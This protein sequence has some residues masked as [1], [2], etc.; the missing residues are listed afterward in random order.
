[1]GLIPGRRAFYAVFLTLAIA[2]LPSGAAAREGGQRPA[3]EA[4]PITEIEVNV[5]YYCELEFSLPSSNGYRITVAG[6]PGRSGV[7]IK[8]VG[9]AGDVDYSTQKGKVTANSIDASFGKLGK[10]SM[11]FRPSDGTRQKLFSKKCQPRRPKS[12]SSQLGEFVGTFRFR[13][14]HGYTRAL[15]HRADGALGD[16]LTNIAMGAIPCEFRE[17][18]AERKREDE[19]VSLQVEVRH[20]NVSFTAGEAFGSLRSAAGTTRSRPYLFLVIAAERSGGLSI[21]R[22]T[23]AIGGSSAFSF[24]PG[25]TQATVAPPAPFSGSGHFRRNSSGVPEWSGN[26]A[27]ELPGLGR[28]GLGRGQA[29]LATVAEHL[30]QFEEELEAQLHP[31]G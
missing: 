19:S 30:K 28:V 24:D 21:L 18:A 5:T 26:L 16:P 13:G 29:E 3:S 17:S 22:S 9:A 1:M 27:V 11:R 23:G 25:L 4:C 2:A 14:E 15:A 6:E 10:V 20:P 12:V 31:S 8:V 7:E